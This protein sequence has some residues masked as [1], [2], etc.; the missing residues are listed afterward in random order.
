MK[1]L[2]K[3]VAKALFYTGVIS[4]AVGLIGGPPAMVVETAKLCGMCFGMNIVIN[5]VGDYITDKL[6]QLQECRKKV[7]NL[8]KRQS[9]IEKNQEELGKTLEIIQKA[10]PTKGLEGFEKD[11]LKQKVEQIGKDVNDLR[12][13]MGETK[14]HSQTN[15]KSNPTKTNIDKAFKNL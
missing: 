2:A 8:E 13:A 12:K 1:Q 5:R 11:V 4:G 7:D 9:I 14:E 15:E 6:D 10:D 3:Q